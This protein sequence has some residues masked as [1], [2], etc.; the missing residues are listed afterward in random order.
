MCRADW[1]IVICI[2]LLMICTFC[3]GYDNGQKITKIQYL[4]K[5]LQSVNGEASNE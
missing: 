5:Q 2:I 1:G 4:E 3:A